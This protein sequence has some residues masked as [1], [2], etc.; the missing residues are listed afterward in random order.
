MS[1]FEGRLCGLRFQPAGGITRFSMV[2][3]RPADC[4]LGGFT[5]ERGPGIGK[6]RAQR[7]ILLTQRLQGI[8]FGEANS[9]VRATV[10][11]VSQYGSEHALRVLPRFTLPWYHAL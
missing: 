4:A 10:G 11:N 1:V 3:R 7:A 2:I 9:Q 5:H 8:D 6:D